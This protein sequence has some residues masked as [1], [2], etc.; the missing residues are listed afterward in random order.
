MYILWFKNNLQSEVAA[1]S[2]SCTMRLESTITVTVAGA[3]EVSAIE[4]LFETE[5]SE[6]A[7]GRARYRL[8]SKD[9]KVEFIVSADDP[10]A[11][12][13]ALNMITKVLSVY[14]KMEL[15]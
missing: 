15:S 10:V 5:D 8:V 11:L 4:K 12:R 14:T 2:G 7:N 3:D 6:L 13:A 1:L 9:D